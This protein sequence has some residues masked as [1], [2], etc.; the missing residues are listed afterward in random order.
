[1]WLETYIQTHL[2]TSSIKVSLYH[3]CRLTR[4]LWVLVSNSV[5]ERGRRKDIGLEM[6]F[7]Y[8]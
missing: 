8:D 4:C 5:I 6:H 1:M 7:A 3:V 2:P